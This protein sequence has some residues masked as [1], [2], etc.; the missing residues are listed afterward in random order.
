MLKNPFLL[1]ILVFGSVLA[2]YQ[3]QWSEIYPDLSLETLVFFCVTFILATGFAFV[4]SRDVKET[5]KYRP[6]RLPGYTPLFLIAVYAADIAYADT[7]PLVS[8]I[9]GSYLY[10]SFPGIPTVHV[11]AVTFSA[12]FATIRF[13]DFLYSKPK[14]FRYLLEALLPLAFFTL[15]NFRG[16]TLI[17]LISWS[18]VYIIKRG[19]LG[20]ART[21]IIA[22]AVLGGLYVFGAFGDLRTGGI[23]ELGRPSQTFRESGI[24]RT[25][26]WGYLYSTAP[27]ANLQYAIDL[28]NPRSDLQSF[29]ELVISE[30]L[31]D[32][33]S[34]RLLP[35]MQVQRVLTPEVGPGLNVATLFGRSY[36]YFGWTGLVLMFGW[37]LTVVTAY[38][39]IIRSSPYR[40]PCLALLNALVVFCCF[41]NMIAQ[42]FVSFQLIWPLLLIPLLAPLERLENRIAARLSR[43]RRRWKRRLNHARREMM[44]PE[45]VSGP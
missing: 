2:I 33:L 31:P 35:L 41:D 38:L 22:A 10:G 30:M 26:F 20:F 25:Y 12:S 28:G 42:T 1:Y 15:L 5:V 44:G 17:T 11:F 40:V 24:P 3:L 4:V 16:V 14:R 37:F 7:I 23:E 34:N 29:V 27:L 45:T 13:A 6:V 32:F 18:F 9:Q 39:V 19:R 21:L 43:L 8:L 36:L